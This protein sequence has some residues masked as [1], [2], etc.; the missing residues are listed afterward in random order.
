MLGL[1]EGSGLEH[2]LALYEVSVPSVENP[3]ADLT[4]ADATA[5]TPAFGCKALGLRV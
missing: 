1:N 2:G 3:K 4:E 5:P